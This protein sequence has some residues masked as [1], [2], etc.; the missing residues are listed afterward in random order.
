MRRRERT[1]PNRMLTKR[2]SVAR[3][4]REIIL[5]RAI[6]EALREALEAGRLL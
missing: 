1:Y 5:M 2:L 3:A 4:E 6:V